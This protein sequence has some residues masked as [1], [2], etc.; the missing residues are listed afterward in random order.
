[1]TQRVLVYDRRV[2]VC[3]RIILLDEKVK[4]RENEKRQVPGKI[5][6]RISNISV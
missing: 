4:C 5:K 1:M 6:W 2:H 3:V